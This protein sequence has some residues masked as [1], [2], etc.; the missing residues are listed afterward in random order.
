[1]RIPSSLITHCVR[2]L[3]QSM[4][5]RTMTMLARRL[6][7]GYDLHDRTG[8]QKSVA[9]P[10]QNAARQVVRDIIACQMFLEFVVLL[11]EFSDRGNGI[12]GRKL[13]IPYLRQILNGVYQLG[14]LYDRSNRIFIENP[15][16]R[17]TRNWGTLKNH[18][19]YTISFLR[20]DIVDNSKL[21]RNNSSGC[22][23]EAYNNLR[24]IVIAS[25]EKR[26][27]RIWGWDGDGGLAAFCFGN[28]H[29]S[30]V[31]S[32]IEVLHE[33]FIFNSI[34]CSIE[35][36]IGVRMA[37]HSGMFEYT[38]DTEQLQA[39]DTVRKVNDLEHKHTGLNKITISEV[40]KVMLEPLTS[41]QF[42]DFKSSDKRIYYQYE[43]R[44]QE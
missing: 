1:M 34:F 16:E 40:V 37:V 26:N 24:D 30:A 38:T 29:E 28:M 7:P 19:E 9:I 2:A 31:L 32:A 14:Y 23:E 11:F 18:Q 21:V 39:S 8:I 4:D 42:K 33:L 20:I 13:A 25:V 35:D 27:G 36:G 6:L 44:V 15:S 10:N 41:N 12:A 17:K 22:I 43:V 5:N 3:S